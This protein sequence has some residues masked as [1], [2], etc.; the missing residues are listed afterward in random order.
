MPIPRTLPISRSRGRTVDE[1]DLDDPA[2]LL[3]D[4]TRQDREPEA[5]DADEDQHGADVG[6]QES[7]PV[8]VGLRVDRIHGGWLLGARNSPGETSASASSA[9]VRRATTAAVTSWAT[10]W[11]G[12]LLEADGPRPGQ[13]GR[14]GDDGRD[15]LVGRAPRRRPPRRRRARPRRRGR[16]GA[17]VVVM[18]RREPGRLRLRRPRSASPPRR[19][20]GSPAGRTIRPR[21]AS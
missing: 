9:C 16:A 6:E 1:D 3:L 11:S 13:V 18:R 20:T 10:N 12:S 4:D 7:R 21:A 8:R 15:R 19:R 14:H 17:A 2:L 5:E